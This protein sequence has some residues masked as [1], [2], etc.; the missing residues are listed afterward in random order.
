[1]SKGRGR[2]VVEKDLIHVP[3]DRPDI[4]VVLDVTGPEP[5]LRDNPLYKP[6]GCVLT[7]HIAGSIGKWD[8]MW[9]GK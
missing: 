5:P 6:A 9:P 7:P 4:T 2:Q 8:C 3:E 1:M